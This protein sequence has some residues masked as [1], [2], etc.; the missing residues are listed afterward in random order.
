MHQNLVFR[1][2]ERHLRSLNI[3]ESGSLDY[4]VPVVLP[5]LFNNLMADIL[6]L[7][8]AIR[9]NDE[10]ACISSLIGN[11]LRNGFFVLRLISAQAQ[12]YLEMKRTSPTL[13]TVG[14][15]KR[16]MGGGELQSL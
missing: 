11:V 2:S 7:A 16:A 5:R 15:L 12:A 13:V 3:A 6:A 10:E 8:I 1:L 14:A 9:P 4:D